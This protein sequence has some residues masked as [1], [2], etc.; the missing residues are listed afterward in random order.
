MIRDVTVRAVIVK[1]GSN[2]NVYVYPRGD[3][4]DGGLQTPVNPKSGKPY[5][6]GYV[7]FCYDL[8][9]P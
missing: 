6:L 1:G 4:S 3:Y 2:A 5:G 9:T 8:A 7:T